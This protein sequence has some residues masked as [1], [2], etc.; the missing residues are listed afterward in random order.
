MKRL[1][2][3]AVLAALLF[4]CNNAPEK[5]TFTVNG[6]FK[7][8][9]AS[10]V[11][12]EELYFNQHPA[13]LMDSAEIKNGKFSFTFS[14]GEEGLYHLRTDSNRE[15]YLL[16]NDAPVI[17]FTADGSIN[18]LGQLNSSSPANTSLKNFTAYFD[19][20]MKIS[21]TKYNALMALQKNQVKETD[22]SFIALSSEYD[23][24]TESLIKYC[25]KYADTAKSPVVALLA[26]TYAPVDK[27]KLDLPLTNLAKR[28]P[29]HNGI[30]GAVNFFRQMTAVQQAPPPP[31]NIG[32]GSMA[33]DI[34][35]N[36]VNGKPF[37]LSSLRGKYVLVDFWASWCGPCRGENPN[38][39][40]AYQ[41][42]KNK[43]FTILGVSLDED[44]AAWQK[45]IAADGLTW[46]HI[47]DLKG[48]HSAAV[49]LYGFDGIPFNVL[50]DPDGKII[51]NSLRGEELTATLAKVLK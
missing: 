25:F 26:T 7:N 43:N 15:G 21:V 22:S 36:D 34:T 13:D 30:T 1:L 18:T 23:S 9:K 35:M 50:V 41:Q 4:S 42:F 37:S 44:K 12:I 45:A 28:F 27:S 5:G 51:A 8:N 2:P 40:A 16:I 32:N 46:Q 33:P 14:A 20:V 48:W 47:S 29:S 31:G 49:S 3:A 6:E 11:Y 10:R 19:S 38:V 39:V 17:N 24:L